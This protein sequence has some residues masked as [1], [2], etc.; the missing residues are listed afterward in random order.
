MYLE[1]E[2][3]LT[4]RTGVRMNNDAAVF[5]GDFL[6]HD[7]VRELPHDIGEKIAPILLRKLLSLFRALQGPDIAGNVASVLAGK[8]VDIFRFSQK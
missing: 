7:I 5:F 3:G 2:V 6:P 1:L 4:P 8:Q